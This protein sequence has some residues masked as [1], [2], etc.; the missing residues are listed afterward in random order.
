RGAVLR[1]ARRGRAPDRSRAAGARATASR[2]GT[3][4]RVAVD[5]VSGVRVRGGA[6][7]AISFRSAKD[8]PVGPFP[9]SVAHQTI[10]CA[11]CSTDRGAFGPPMSVRT[12]PGHALLT[13]T[14]DAWVSAASVR[15]KPFSAVFE[16]E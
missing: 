5:G 2:A 8:P 10:V 6:H 12:H 16:M 9:G 1:A 13:R 7:H 15:V 4:R 11:P 14:P 3:A